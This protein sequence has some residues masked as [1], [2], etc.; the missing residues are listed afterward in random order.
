MQPSTNTTVT[1]AMMGAATGGIVVYLAELFGKV[2]IP[3]PVE[4]MVL[5]LCTGLVALLYPAN[6]PA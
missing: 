1:G 5:V 3:S 4:G 2:D 6:P